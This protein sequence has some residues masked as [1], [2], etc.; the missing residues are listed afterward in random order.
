MEYAD[1]FDVTA[2]G[3]LKRFLLVCLAASMQR[4][5]TGSIGTKAAHWQHFY[6]RFH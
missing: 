4:I 3:A 2:D 5:I 6:I 1:F